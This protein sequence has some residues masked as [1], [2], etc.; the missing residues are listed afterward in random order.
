LAAIRVTANVATAM[1]TIAVSFI[2]CLL[3]LLLLR[4]AAE[5]TRQHR[6]TQQRPAPSDIERPLVRTA[7][8]Q[9]LA[10]SRDAPDGDNAKMLAG[11][12]HHLD[13]RLG[14]RV[15]A[16]LLVD[17]QAVGIRERLRVRRD[18]LI[19]PHVSRKH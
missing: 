16:A 8:G 10:A 5:A 3:S 7:E 4:A 2:R 12:A 15:E 1:A 13:A 9:V 19:A 11:G 18:R 17:D 14:E 6:N